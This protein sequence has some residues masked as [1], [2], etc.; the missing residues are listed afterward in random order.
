MLL[1]YSRLDCPLCEDAEQSLQR[2]GLVYNFI[3]I[4][5]DETLRKKYNTRVPVIVN[6]RGVELNWPFDS[7]ELMDLT[8]LD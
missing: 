8:I 3:D 5:S 4:D 2:L 6:D 1:L 7:K